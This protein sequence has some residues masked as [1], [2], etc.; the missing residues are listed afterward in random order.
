VQHGLREAGVAGRDAKKGFV[1]AAGA[2]LNDFTRRAQLPVA[3]GESALPPRLT[4]TGTRW[5]QP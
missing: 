3:A 4:P 1:F 5:R 2:P